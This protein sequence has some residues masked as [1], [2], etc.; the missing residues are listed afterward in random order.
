MAG[1]PTGNGA[2][3]VR[4]VSKRMATTLSELLARDGVAQ[5]EIDDELALIQRMV[6]R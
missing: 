2:N 1:V 4:S 6:A 3:I 5:A